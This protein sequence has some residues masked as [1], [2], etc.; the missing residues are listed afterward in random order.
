MVF[1]NV[2]VNRVKKKKREKKKEARQEN[3]DCVG[4]LLKIVFSYSR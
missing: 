2:T 3:S 4:E 1:E